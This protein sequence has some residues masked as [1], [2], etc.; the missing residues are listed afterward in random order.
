M[1]CILLTFQSSITSLPLPITTQQSLCFFQIVGVPSLAVPVAWT[2]L[3]W[4]FPMA[5]DFSSFSFQLKTISSERHSITIFL[6]L[7]LLF[8][9]PRVRSSSNSLSTII[10]SINRVF[11]NIYWM[12]KIIHHAYRIHFFTSTFAHVGAPPRRLSYSIFTNR[13]LLFILWSNLRF[14]S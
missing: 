14:T 6:K 10:S 1:I 11:S 4:A 2:E 13:C 3:L 7:P 8:V 12:S 5:D 9:Y